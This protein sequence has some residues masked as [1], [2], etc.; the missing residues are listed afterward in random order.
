MALYCYI[1]KNYKKL[2][3]DT[4]MN[5]IGAG[6]KLFDNSDDKMGSDKTSE[7]DGQESTETKQNLIERIEVARDCFMNSLVKLGLD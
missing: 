6:G 3:S 7:A 4:A 5:R 1:K 2:V